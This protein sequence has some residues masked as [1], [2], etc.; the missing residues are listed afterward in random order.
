MGYKTLFE[1]HHLEIKEG[2]SFLDGKI[3]QCTSVGMPELKIHFYF[4]EYYGHKHGTQTMLLKP[5]PPLTFHLLRRKNF[6]TL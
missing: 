1:K 2:E 3:S 6:G 5:P 4:N